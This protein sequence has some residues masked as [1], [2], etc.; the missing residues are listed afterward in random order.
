MGTNTRRNEP[1]LEPILRSPRPV[2]EADSHQLMGLI[3]A[4]PNDSNCQRQSF[5][6]PGTVPPW[7]CFG[8]DIILLVHARGGFAGRP[9]HHRIRR[10]AKGGDSRGG[11]ATA[12]A[13]RICGP[14][15][16]AILETDE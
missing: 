16:S 7:S 1:G 15:T 5:L 4:A 2:K 13:V 6:D 8:L 11:G 9:V 14:G 3:L 10:S 12:A